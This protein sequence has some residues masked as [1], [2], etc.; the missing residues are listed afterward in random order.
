MRRSR[1]GKSKSLSEKTRK[2]FNRLRSALFRFG[3]LK[4]ADLSMLKAY[5]RAYARWEEARSEVTKLGTIIGTK[6]GKIIANPCLA[7]E[8]KAMEDLKGFIMNLRLSPLSRAGM[9]R[10]NPS[11][12][13]G[14]K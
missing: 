3:F 7:V 6:K 11:M 14:Q 8:N 5:C 4:K 1:A 13:K 10:N 12:T 9:K 2:E